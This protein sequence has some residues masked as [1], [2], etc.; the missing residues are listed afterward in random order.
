MIVAIVHPDESVTYLAGDPAAP[1]RGFAD[2]DGLVFAGEFEVRWVRPIRSPA[3]RPLPPDNLEATVTFA[4]TRTFSSAE[5]ANGYAQNW[6]PPAHGNVIF[7][8]TGPVEGETYLGM[9]CPVIHP[10][11][12]T[13]RGR[14]LTLRHRITGKPPRELSEPE[15]PPPLPPLAARITEATD[16]SWFE[17]G[18]RTTAALTGNAAAGWTDADGH[19]WRLEQSTDLATWNLA[20]FTD[21]AGS[22][23]HLGGGLYEYWSR[24]ATPRRWKSV[25]VDLTATTDR[26]G[27]SITAISV[28]GTAISG[29]SYPYAMPADAARLQADLRTA[30][31]SGAVVSSA[32]A[33]LVARARNY[34]VNGSFDL[35]VTMSG[36][37]VTG[38]ADDQGNAISLPSYPYAMPGQQAAL[39]ADLRTAGHS[40]AVVTLHADQWSVLLPDRLAGMRRPFVLTINPGD[41]YPIWDMYGTYLGLAAD[42]TITGTYGNVRDPNGQPLVETDEQFARLA[43][44]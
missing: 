11:E 20:R 10:P 8:T 25:R 41:P 7:Q 32:A 15:P 21:C 24:A 31:F 34:T 13:V 6:Q 33:A 38:V 29:L 23:A 26:Y 12:M 39:Q 9:P 16:G 35:L 27:K 19:Q 30:G 2:S 37:N 40:G 28:L 1:D 3:A 36:N 42:A 4:A 14:S 22:P 18:F 17:V 44:T 5:E 43:I